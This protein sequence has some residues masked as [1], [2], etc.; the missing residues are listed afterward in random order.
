MVFAL[1]F[2]EGLAE[3]TDKG[4]QKGFE[5]IREEIDSTAEIQYPTLKS[6]KVSFKVGLYPV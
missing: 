3:S 5:R 4:L 6:N 1:G 2:L